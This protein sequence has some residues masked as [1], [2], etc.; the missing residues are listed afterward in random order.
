MDEK[1]T[2]NHAVMI[3]QSYENAPIV[4]RVDRRLYRCRI[5]NVE[6]SLKAG[7]GSRFSLKMEL[8]G[9][10]STAEELKRDV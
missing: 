6:E 2:I 3:M 4:V 5:Q 7:E 8:S 10:E 9:I 1:I